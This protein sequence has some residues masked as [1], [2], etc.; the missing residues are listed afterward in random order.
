MPTIGRVT[1]GNPGSNRTV[2]ISQLS[3]TTI[4]A[5]NFQHKMNVYM[6]DIKDVDVHNVQTGQTL[7]YNHVTQKYEANSISAIAVSI[8][9]G[10]Y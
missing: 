2:R 5:P 7:I 1:V 9:G 4:Y 8:D 3:Q 10:T 6:S